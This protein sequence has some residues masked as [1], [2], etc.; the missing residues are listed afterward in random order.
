MKPALRSNLKKAYARFFREM[1]I[2]RDTGRL[3]GQVGKKFATYPYVGSKS[4]HARKILFVG[5]DIGKDPKPGH[6]PT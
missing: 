6:K 3:D 4:G 1:D 5:L 2:D